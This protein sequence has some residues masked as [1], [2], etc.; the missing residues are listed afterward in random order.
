MHD[1]TIKMRTWVASNS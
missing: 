1:A